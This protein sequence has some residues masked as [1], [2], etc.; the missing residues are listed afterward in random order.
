MVLHVLLC[1]EPVVFT[2]AG[3]SHFPIGSCL[4]RQLLLVRLNEET[5]HLLWEGNR[6]GNEG[7]GSRFLQ[8]RRGVEVSACE[9]D[10]WLDVKSK[11]T[12][13]YEF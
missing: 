8:G 13:L 6:A 11:P 1:L 12:I 4:L 5:F 9:E 7:W 3:C 10:G 2:L